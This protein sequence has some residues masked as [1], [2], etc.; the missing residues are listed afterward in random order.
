MNVRLQREQRKN[1]REAES[2]VADRHLHPPLQLLTGL[3][4]YHRHLLAVYLCS[5]HE[6][7]FLF[8]LVLF[9]AAKMFAAETQASLWV[10]DKGEDCKT[11]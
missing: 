1:E 3:R 11:L 5:S 10:N 2:G 4:L 7:C 8:L 9:F 6:Y